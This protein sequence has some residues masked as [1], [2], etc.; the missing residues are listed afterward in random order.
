MPYKSNILTPTQIW[1]AAMP[2]VLAVLWST[3]FIGAKFGLPYAEPATFLAYRYALVA[4]ILFI[5]STLTKAPWPGSPNT[6]IHLSVAGLLMQV[7]GVGGVYYGIY[8]GVDAGVTALVNGL[9]PVLVAIIAVSLLGERASKMQWVGFIMGLGGTVLVIWR[10]LD[11]GVGTP[12]GMSLPVCGLLAL[13]IGLTYQKKYCEEMDL[14]TG[15][16]VQTTAAAIGMWIISLS[17]ETGTIEWTGEFIFAFIWLTIVLSLGAI[18]LL[19]Y[20]IRRGQASRVSSLFF[21]VPPITA[22]MSYFMFDE[23]FGPIAFTGMIV[24]VVGVALV[25]QKV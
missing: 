11:L 10:K 12:L 17:L 18:T 9:Q 1:F 21:L 3:G 20:L 8:L 7:V 16:F 5:V 6:Y 24:A 22:V 15:M 25:N 23:T 13:S 19:L 4:T 2:G 14:R